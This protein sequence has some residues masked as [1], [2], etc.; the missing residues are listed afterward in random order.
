MR[1]S[2]RINHEL[3]RSQIRKVAGADAPG[4]TCA[5]CG[6]VSHATRTVRKQG[7]HLVT[8][9]YYLPHLS[10]EELYKLPQ[11]ESDICTARGDCEWRQFEAAILRPADDVKEAPDA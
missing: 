2:T 1:P 7:R 6:K 10:E 5:L 3:L 11:G 9:G 8:E 4:Q